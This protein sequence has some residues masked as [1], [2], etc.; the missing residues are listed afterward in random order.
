MAD[1]IRNDFAYRTI[2]R[3]MSMLD[4]ELKEN[5][6]L[7][8]LQI[9]ESARMAAARLREAYDLFPVN[10][11]ILTKEAKDIAVS[12]LDRDLAASKSAVSEF[13]RATELSEKISYC[14]A[15]SAECR[16]EGSPFQIILSGI[17]EY[18]S[19]YTEKA[20]DKRVS[21]VRSAGTDR[22]FEE[23][24][25]YLRGV[26]ASPFDDYQSVFESVRSGSFGIIPL[27][28][29]NDGPVLSFYRQLEYR[30]ESVV[31]AHSYTSDND[32]TTRYGLIRRSLTYVPASGDRYF[33]CR[34]TF[35]NNSDLS[36]LVFAADAFGTPVES[37]TSLPIGYG[38]RDDSY[39][40][41]FSLSGGDMC[42]LFTFLA[43][44]FPQFAPY[45][46]YTEV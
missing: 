24:A 37:V 5:F 29:D 9:K 41:R 8:L 15:I 44:Y 10:A 35:R 6:E 43:I 31:L 32:N 46:M 21:F 11:L 42:A 12:I 20:G 13:L 1:D 17:A 40:L 28:D 38:G 27:C 4:R 30:S 16:Y 45:G 36:D 34:I 23:F 25:K 22:A 14:K 26:V 19:K 39:I 33:E 18:A 2:S 7:R 3:N